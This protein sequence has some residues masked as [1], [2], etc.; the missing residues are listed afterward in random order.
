MAKQL[1]PRKAIVNTK[2]AAEAEAVLFSKNVRI[3]SSRLI[4][5]LRNLALH[6]SSEIEK[7]M[8]WMCKIHA[9]FTQKMMWHILHNTIE[10]PKI[11]HSV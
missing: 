2:V 7:M 8:R 9:H 5:S 4:K 3:L 10:A 1:R 6:P 11:I